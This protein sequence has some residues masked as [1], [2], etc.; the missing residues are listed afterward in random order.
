MVNEKYLVFHEDVTDVIVIGRGHSGR[1]LVR[2]R[3]ERG[4]ER[5][6]QSLG[7]GIG[8]GMETL[9]WV[10]EEEWRQTFNQISVGYVT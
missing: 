5:Q 8:F 1:E 2:Q 3:V 6:I 10:D 9:V 7:E 4:F